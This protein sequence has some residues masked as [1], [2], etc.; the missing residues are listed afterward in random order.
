MNV[1]SKQNL[2]YIDGGRGFAVDFTLFVRPFTAAAWA[3]A[4]A[5][6]A[7]WAINAT[8]MMK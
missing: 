6:L 3:A 2:A 4:M 1:I 8:A 5:T 7:L